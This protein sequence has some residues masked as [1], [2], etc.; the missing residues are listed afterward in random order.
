MKI[1]VFEN[2]NDEEHID[3]YCRDKDS[4]EI[5]RI[6]S[7]LHSDQTLMARDGDDIIFVDR[8][9]IIYAEYVDR[10]VFIYTECA[11]LLANQSLKD[12]DEVVPDLIRCSKNTLVNL[13]FI[14]K[15]RSLPGGRIIA[16]L[17]NGEQLLISRHYAA[18][19][20]HL[21]M[22]NNRK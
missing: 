4:G 7:F 13:F 6:L 20:R 12:L 3:I 16:T 21:L 22:A 15:L 5:K 11:E 9:D 19:I 18:T 17:K 14:K 10:K 8:H 1:K 2:P